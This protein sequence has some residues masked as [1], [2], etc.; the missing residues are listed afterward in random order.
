M[1][2]IKKYFTE[3]SNLNLQ[4]LELFCNLILEWNAKINLIS[5]KDAD[6]I[7]QN[8]LLPSLAI[9]KILKLEGSLKILDV[10]TGG[11]FPGL[12]LAICYPDIP[13][14]LLDSIGKKL[15][16]I[17]NIAKH[18]DLHNVT[19]IQTR[20]ES[21]KNTYD[22]VLGRAVTA[23]PRFIPWVRKNI[24]AGKK[25]NL[26]NGILYLKGGDISEEINALGIPPTDIYALNTLYDNKYCLDKHLIYFKKSALKKTKTP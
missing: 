15:S 12:P 23:L 9:V 10:G 3:L 13:F 20:I 8:H 26:E 18:L 5:R 19:T 1:D 25:A 4:K 14:V 11:G 21:H 6:N 17:Q 7:V 16:V 24:Q 22:F 2:L